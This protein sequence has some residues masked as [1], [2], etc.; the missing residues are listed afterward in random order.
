MCAS[1]TLFLHV[2]VCVS[3]LR[4]YIVSNATTKTAT[5][6]FT[7]HVNGGCLFVTAVDIAGS[8]SPP[9]PPSLRLAGDY[10]AIPTI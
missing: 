1:N 5:R 2:C 10:Y 9:P 6:A 3:L 8:L 4:L 7:M